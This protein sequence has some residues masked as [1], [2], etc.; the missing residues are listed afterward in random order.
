MTKARKT[1]AATT[2]QEKAAMLLEHG[3]DA[4]QNADLAFRTLKSEYIGRQIMGSAVIMGVGAWAL[5][6]NITGAG[7]QDDAERRRMMSIGWKPF[8]IRNPITGE[9]RSYR[10][11]EPFSQ[12]MGLTADIVYQAN[13]VDQSL[14]ED[15]FRKASYAITMNVTNGTFI[16]GF[17]PLAGLI[18]GDPSAWTR[19]FAQQTDML[20]PY[21]GVRTVLNNVITPVSYTH[22]T[23]PTKA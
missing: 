4:S 21:K 2:V 11:L 10:G 23:L 20:A 15:W 5:E 19:F 1:L 17:E 13:R 18:S 9:W 12:L 16:S 6:G 22:L 14:T 8:S 7:P 3:I